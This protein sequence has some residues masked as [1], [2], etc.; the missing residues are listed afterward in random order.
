[1]SNALAHAPAERITYDPRTGRERRLV[2]LDQMSVP[3]RHVGDELGYIPQARSGAINVKVEHT[4]DPE[5]QE[6]LRALRKGAPVAA[7][8]GGAIAGAA[9]L[10]L[11]LWLMQD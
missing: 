6:T 3:E 4:L 2:R 5:A 11:V 7:A 8:V 1:M 10:G 9:V